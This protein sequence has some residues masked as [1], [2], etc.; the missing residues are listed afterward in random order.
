VDSAGFPLRPTFNPDG[1]AYTG[2]LRCF[3]VFGNVKADGSP[4]TSADCPGGVAATTGTPWDTF[5]P[6]MDSTGHIA[7]VL[8]KMP[9]ANYFATGD[10]LNTAGFQWVRGTSG[11][12]GANAAAGVSDFVN[13]QQIN[14]K[15]DQ[16]FKKTRI[17]GSWS[18]QADD[19]ADFVASWPEGLNGETRRRPQVLTLTG[20]TTISATMLNE[21]RF[22]LRYQSTGRF[23]AAESSNP[24][25]N[26]EA[27]SWF[28]NGGT[29][30]NGTVYPVAFTPA[31]VG[32]GYVSI[33]SQNSGDT[34]P[35]YDY[36]DTFSWSHG[37][38]ALKFGAEY[39]RTGSNGYNSTGGSVIPNITGGASANLNS[40]LTTLGSFATQLPIS[41]NCA[42]RIRKSPVFP[43]RVRC[44]CVATLLDRRCQ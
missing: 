19:S 21:A 10:G 31:G 22:G 13:R 2:G 7:R 32:N 14:I 11:Q 44:Q 18:Y 29:N 12:G 3:S 28:L 41:C 17:S 35:L 38:H 42:Y 5:R 15:I 24:S 34:T 27:N 40:P 43:E 6:G 4:F 1:T 30:P 37:R 9:I 25:V 36:A 23:I 16:N 8:S 26:S 20:T 33:A 39:R